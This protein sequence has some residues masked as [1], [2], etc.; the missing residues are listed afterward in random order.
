[1]KLFKFTALMA[2]LLALMLYTPAGMAEDDGP[3]G[4]DPE[5]GDICRPDDGPPP[6]A[7]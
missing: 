7:D 4:C 3:V 5:A 2:A 6:S 1:M